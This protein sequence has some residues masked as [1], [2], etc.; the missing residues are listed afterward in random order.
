MISLVTSMMTAIYSRAKYKIDFQFSPIPL[1]LSA[2]TEGLTA[3]SLR[4]VLFIG[5]YYNNKFRSTPLIQNQTVCEKTGLSLRGVQRAR[6]Q[7]VEAGI[8][9]ADQQD[10]NPKSNRWAYKWTAEILGFDPAE[11]D[12]SKPESKPKSHDKDVGASDKDVG[13]SD[14]DVD[15]TMSLD[16]FLNSMTD[17]V[18]GPKKKVEKAD[19]RF[20]S[21]DLNYKR[22]FEESKSEAT[23]QPKPVAVASGFAGGNKVIDLAD[24]MVALVESRLAAGEVVDLNDWKALAYDALHKDR[25]GAKYLFQSYPELDLHKEWFTRVRTTHKHWREG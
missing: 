24:K 17:K 21:I 11:K 3:Q 6:N 20:K 19:I 15:K 5:I 14:K 1:R 8:I 23:A 9:V 12:E 4:L 16:E 25:E 10:G 22:G 13:A 7:L 2:K 18:S